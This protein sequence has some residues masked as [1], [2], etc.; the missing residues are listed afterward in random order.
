MNHL[1]QKRA[2]LIS[3]LRQLGRI[4]VAFSAGVDSTF[5]LSIARE[6]LGD[7]VI[8]ITGRSVS[9]PEREQTEAADFCRSLGIEQVVVTVDQMSIEGFRNNPPDRCYLC[10]KELFSAFRAAAREKGFEYVAEGSNI[11]DLGDYRPGLRAIKELGIISPLK[12][13]G[14]T[15]NEIRQLSQEM[16]LPTWSK[17]SFA[18]LATRIP[19]GDDITKE[20][21]L[22]IERGERQLFD[23]GFRQVRVRVHGRIARIEIDKSEFSKILEPEVSEAIDQYFMALGFQYVTLDLG[24]YQ[25]GSMNKSLSL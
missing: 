1:T 8:A 15:K 24:G 25:M 2:D 7:N 17:P 19:Y 12:E 22:M 3:Y 16:G 20:K 11:D 4:A 9:F 10:K 13:A 18:C 23:L 5:L 14:L 6:A 21:L